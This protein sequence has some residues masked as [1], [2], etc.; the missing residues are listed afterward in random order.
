MLTKKLAYIQYT[1][2][3]KLVVL[4]IQK[5][6]HITVNICN[7]SEKIEEYPEVI[8]KLV[9]RALHYKCEIETRQSITSNTPELYEKLM[10]YIEAFR[11]SQTLILKMCKKRNLRGIFID[12][13]FVKY[14]R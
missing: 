8:Q 2:K 10:R 11:Q 1:N 3:Q 13:G 4:D 6:P 7:A 5:R 12:G 9:W 14:R